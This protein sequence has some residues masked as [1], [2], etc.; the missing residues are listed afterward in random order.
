MIDRCQALRRF[1]I[2]A[3]VTTATACAGIGERVEAP[4]DAGV[5]THAP[6]VDGARA[7]PWCTAAPLAAP[8][9]EYRESIAARNRALGTPMHRVRLQALA[10]QPDAAT[11]HPI[12]AN[13][14]DGVL[15]LSPDAARA[16]LLMRAAAA[17]DGVDLVPVSAYRSP[18]AQAAIVE[19]KRD[20]GRDWAKLL[21]RNVPPG[22]SEH[23]TGDAIDI[24]TPEVPGLVEAFARTE[25][26]AWLQDNAARYCFELS[27][28]RHNAAGVDFEPWHWRFV[29]LAPPSAAQRPD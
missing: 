5:A 23:H 26:Y 14:G 21:R 25:A 19:R 17:A 28:P 12:T 8:S 2:A 24:A 11:L 6:S 10:L 13:E 9:A 1:A 4:A 15:A 18:A 20:G 3:V 7:K 16:W 22:Y 27:Y 29:R